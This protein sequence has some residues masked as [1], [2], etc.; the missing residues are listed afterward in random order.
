MHVYLDL[1]F[2]LHSSQHDIYPKYCA[3]ESDSPAISRYAVPSKKSFL[4]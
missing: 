1:Y 3:G 4:M 2:S